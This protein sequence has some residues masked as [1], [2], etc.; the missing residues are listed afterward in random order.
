MDPAPDIVTQAVRVVAALLSLPQALSRS[1]GSSMEG[2]GA[3][4]SL[5]TDNMSRGSG[6]GG[7]GVLRGSNS[8]GLIGSQRMGASDRCKGASVRLRLRATRPITTTDHRRRRRHRH[9][10]R[11]GRHGRHVI[12]IIANHPSSHPLTLSPAHP[13]ATSPCVRRSPL[14][15]SLAGGAR[16]RSSRASWHIVPTRNRWCSAKVS[17]A[18]SILLWLP[19]I[20]RCTWCLLLVCRCSKHIQQQ[21]PLPPPPDLRFLR[22]I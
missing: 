2:A 20:F 13:L 15:R 10:G 4:R 1:R 8:S 18:A 12:I 7:L 17:G 6:G 3:N 16:R 19:I 5:L 9:Y 11:Y 22:P 21:C 14:P